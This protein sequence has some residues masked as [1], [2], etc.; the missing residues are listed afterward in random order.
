MTVAGRNAMHI[1]VFV[2]QVIRAF[3]IE[4]HVH[5]S[6]GTFR[7]LYIVEQVHQIRSVV[8]Q[9]SG[10]SLL[11]EDEPPYALPTTLLLRVISYTLRRPRDVGII[12]EFE[13]TL[14]D[15][16]IRRKRVDIVHPQ[17]RI[18]LTE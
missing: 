16:V 5:R 2:T 13:D 14:H 18:G 7:K 12:N 8:R 17:D 3:E 11:V 15:L 4:V 10:R 1:L 9:T 6:S